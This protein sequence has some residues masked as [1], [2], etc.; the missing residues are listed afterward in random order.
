M[1]KNSVYEVITN[2]ILNALKN[3]IIPWRIPWQYQSM[4]P[5][6]VRGTPYRGSNYLL[7]L[8]YTAIKN[9]SS[10]YWL[11]YNQ[12]QQYGGNVKSGEKAWPVVFWKKVKSNNSKSKNIE[13]TDEDEA[14]WIIK[15]YNVFNLDQTENVT[16]ELPIDNKIISRVFTPIEMAESIV[17]AYPN[18][19]NIKYTGNGASYNPSMDTVT[20]PPREHFHSDED[21]YDTLFHELAHSTG[22]PSRLGRLTKTYSK[23][24]KEYAMEELIAELTGAFLCAE[25]NISRSVIDNQAAYID[26]YLSYFQDNKTAFVSA[27]S[28]AQRAADYILNRKFDQQDDPESNQPIENQLITQKSA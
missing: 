7:L 24:D 20:M 16:I 15:Y 28:K 22:H 19:P 9:Y 10:P 23:H 25:A 4:R 11:T 26:G 8:I 2:Q 18:P 27:A 17:N 14:Y 6:N 5:T 13:N 21:L 12:A 3:G 1:F